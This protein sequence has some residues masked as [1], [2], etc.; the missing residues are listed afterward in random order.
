MQQFGEDLPV[1]I[2]VDLGIGVL[3]SL[4]DFQPEPVGNHQSVRLKPWTDYLWV[5][6]H[7]FVTDQ[8]VENWK[9]VQEWAA[10]TVLLTS[11]PVQK[12]PDSLVILLI[13]AWLQNLV[14]F[15]LEISLEGP[16]DGIDVNVG[17]VLNRKETTVMTIW[18]A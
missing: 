18:A 4:F 12:H 5:N 17:V 10:Y 2:G 8:P 7:G 11:Q 13:F 15:R 16:L 6:I 3:L 9:D 14:D 1:D